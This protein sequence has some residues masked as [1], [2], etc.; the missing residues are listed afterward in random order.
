MV[1]FCFFFQLLTASGRAFVGSIGAFVIAG[2]TVAVPSSSSSSSPDCRSAQARRKSM[3]RPSLEA[4]GEEL[5]SSIGSTWPPA[6]GTT[7]WGHYIWRSIDGYDYR[8]I[9]VFCAALTP[10][11]DA[12]ANEPNDSMG[13]EFCASILWHSRLKWLMLI[14]CK[15]ATAPSPQ[16]KKQIESYVNRY[17]AGDSTSRAYV[18]DKLDLNRPSAN[19]YIQRSDTQKT[20][21]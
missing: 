21:H 1:C 18:R 20:K 11:W 13:A 4:A 12:D 3:N 8:N 9:Q 17:G 15:L 2:V 10:K 6:T 5:F 14:N 19:N 16:A 7:I